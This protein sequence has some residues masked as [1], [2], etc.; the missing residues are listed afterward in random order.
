MSVDPAATEETTA[1][2]RQSLS[3]EAARNLAT[4]TKSAPQ[5]QGISSR[6][7][8]RILPWVQTGGGTYRVNRT[9]S[10]TL[11]DGRISFV[12]TGTELRV[13][14]AMLRELGMLRHF[15]DDAVVKSIA[16]RFV[17]EEFRK[18]DV[19][20]RRGEPVDK[21]FLIAHGRIERLA[22][23]AYGEEAALDVLSDGDHFGHH[24]LPDSRWEF[25]ARAQTDVVTMTYN[26]GDW[27]AALNASPALRRHAEAYLEAERV[28]R[29]GSD[30]VDLSSGHVGEPLLPGT[31]VDYDLSPREYEL[32][33]AQTV[34][35]VHTRVADLYNH[36][37]NQAEQQLRLTVEA[38]KERQESELV[39]N[40]EFGLLHNADYEQRIYTRTGPPTPDDL[41]ELL[42]RRRGSQYFLAHPRTIAAFGRECSRRGLYPDSV[43][44]QG[45]RMPSWRGLPLLPCNKIPVTR[46]RTSSILVV[47]TGEDNEGVIGLHQT[48]LPDE[49]Q[50][51]LSVRFMHI[52]EQ[53]IIS[54]LVS[55]YY[56]AAILVPDAVGV[57]ENVEISRFDD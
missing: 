46:E 53:A 4:T 36:P 29:K 12:K 19:I 10:Y 33:V 31:Y 11:G 50:P 2:A 51:G 42:S 20:V 56:S 40:P 44:F 38:L 24:P 18:G 28:G 8:L 26:R 7:L 43:D 23:T 6:W 14:P 5:M 48:G 49:Y 39:N 55:L 41:D 52:N 1:A 13:I 34:L 17:K 47:R 27:D 15:P 45:H 16:D 21:I 37:M 57:L 3:T 32:S 22:P 35:R 9:V 25:T 30:A 54:Y